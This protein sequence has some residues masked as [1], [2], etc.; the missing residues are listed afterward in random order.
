MVGIII[1]LWECVLFVLLKGGGWQH[2]RKASTIVR[3]DKIEVLF[4]KN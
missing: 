3:K 2:V 1:V 4:S